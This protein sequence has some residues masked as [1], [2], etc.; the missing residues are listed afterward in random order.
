M[1]T[2]ARTDFVHRDTE[3][4]SV[5]A[6]S[7]ENRATHGMRGREREVNSSLR[8]DSLTPAFAGVKARRKWPILHKNT[9][10]KCL[11]WMN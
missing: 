4:E 2:G 7:H 9:R 8:L 10:D 3:R 11:K 1:E 5:R 6:A